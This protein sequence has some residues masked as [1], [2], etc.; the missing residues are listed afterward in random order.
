[1]EFG[2]TAFTLLFLALCLDR[3]DAAGNLQVDVLFGIDTGQFSANDVVAALGEV[4]DA[5]PLP[6]GAGVTGQVKSAGN[7]SSTSR[8]ASP[9]ETRDE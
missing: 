3:Q 7:A 9:R 8:R 1:M 5:D 6:A 4:R 2:A